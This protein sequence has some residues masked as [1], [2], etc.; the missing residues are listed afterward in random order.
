MCGQMQFPH[1]M[2]RKVRANGKYCWLFDKIKMSP[3]CPYRLSRFFPLFRLYL[4]SSLSEERQLTDAHTVLKI[5]N[6]LPVKIQR[7]REIRVL[8]IILLPRLS[9]TV[10][11]TWI[12][13]IFFFFFL[14]KTSYELCA[15]FHIIRD[16]SNRTLFCAI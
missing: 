5:K 2:L 15:R 1:R 8:S 6:I 9:V 16:P 11:R 12:S 10:L 4:P 13:R 14:K 7:A 3:T